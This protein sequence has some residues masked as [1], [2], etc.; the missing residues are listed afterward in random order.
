[1]QLNSNPL[2]FSSREVI[3]K[4]SFVIKGFPAT[5]S[6]SNFKSIHNNIVM[7]IFTGF[8][9]LPHYKVE[10]FRGNMYYVYIMLTC[11]KKINCF[12]NKP[13]VTLYNFAVPPHQMLLYDKS[14]ADVSGVVGPLEE[15]SALVLVCEVRGGKS[16]IFTPLTYQA[17]VLK[18]IIFF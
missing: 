16:I 2:G 12:L 1:M 10:A 4:K 6:A 3:C 5:K 14:G 18:L 11:K 7:G 17:C 9:V 15:G 8:S 13:L